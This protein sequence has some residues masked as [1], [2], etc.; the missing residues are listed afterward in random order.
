MS[1]FKKNCFVVST[2]MTTQ[3]FLKDQIQTLSRYFEITCV[4]N[5]TDNPEYKIVW[6]RV[7]IK[8]IPLSRSVK[9]LQDLKALFK[10]FLFFRKEQFCVIHTITPKAGLIGMLAA[11]LAGT[12]IRIHTFTGQV[13]VTR[14]GMAYWFLKNIDLVIG[15]LTTHAYTDSSSQ[16]DFLIK[17]KIIQSNK[18]KTLAD[19]SI[20]GV[21]LKKFI[22]SKFNRNEIRN[23]L[24]LN[25]DSVIILFLGRMNMDKGVKDLVKAFVRIDTEN[26]HL[27]LVGPD[28][29]GMR[30]HLF[31]TEGLFP[32]RIHFVDYTSEPEKY[33]AAA[34]IFCL[35]SYREGFGSTI[36]EAAACGLPS[37]ASR[38]YGLTDA[39]IHGVTGFLYPP[40][41]IESL[42]QAL[43][44]LVENPTFRNRMGKTARNRAMDLFSQKRMT[45]ALLEEYFILTRQDLC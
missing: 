27:L 26:T 8:D 22:P 28:E 12:K 30:K 20:S 24:G 35:P 37:V 41:N 25:K 2:P 5:Y 40:G 7:R 3:V 39:V 36:I 19:G 31:P 33:M 15:F 23:A 4:A 44:K 42:L 6:G 18:I 21:D 29:C 13:W 34:D 11:F 16:R 1:A 9:P 32:S 14:K 45:Q 17:K 10:L 38:I 43:V